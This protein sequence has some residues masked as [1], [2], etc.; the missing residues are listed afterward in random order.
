M[1][2]REKWQNQVST[3]LTFVREVMTYL[4]SLLIAS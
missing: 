2:R 4:L 1:K 3:S